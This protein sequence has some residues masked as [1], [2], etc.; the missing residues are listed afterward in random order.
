[1]FSWCNFFVFGMFGIVV[2]V[3]LLLLIL[4]LLW[5]CFVF[6]GSYCFVVVVFFC[7]FCGHLKTFQQL[8]KK[9]S[10]PTF[11]QIAFL[12]GLIVYAQHY[13]L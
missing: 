1:M 12:L 8:F 4:G 9:Y 5:C 13:T 3:L 7:I 10:F 6:F 11:G 2:F